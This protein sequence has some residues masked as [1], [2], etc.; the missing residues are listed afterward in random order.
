MAEAKKQGYRSRAA[1]KAAAARREVLPAAPADSAS[2]ISE[3]RPAAG[4][5][6]RVAR[7]QAG[8]G[9]GKVVALDYLEM[10]PVP[11]ADVLQ[12]DF[13]DPEA[14]DRLKAALVRPGRLWCSATWLRRPPAMP[15]PT[16]SGSWELVRVSRRI[17]PPRS[18]PRD[19]A[20]VCKLFQG[21]AEKELLDR[22]KRD[23]AKVQARQAGGEP[24][25][26]LRDLS[27]CDTGSAAEPL[28]FGHIGQAVLLDCRPLDLDPL[29]TPL[30]WASSSDGLLWVRSFVTSPLTMSRVCWLNTVRRFAHHRR[31]LPHQHQPVDLTFPGDRIQPLRNRP[32]ANAVLSWRCQSAFGSMACRPGAESIMHPAG[33]LGPQFAGRWALTPDLE[34]AGDGSRPLPTPTFL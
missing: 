19:G 6:L 13:L 17:S 25:G 27:G 3:P 5:R 18:W 24:F 32:G 9:S 23:F 28:T 14:P 16:I 12:V 22:L 31:R 8:N 7:G 30:I 2:S 20:F 15:R 33:P 10:D 29:S 26:L 21:G 11:G 34:K 1:F 4:P